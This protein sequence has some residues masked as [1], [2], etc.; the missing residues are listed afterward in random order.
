MINSNF[1]FRR[2][3]VA[4]HPRDIKEWNEEYNRLGTE[5]EPRRYL[6]EN[7]LVM[8]QYDHLV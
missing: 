7:E 3:F 8:S 4:R 6:D 5:D 2:S 1:N